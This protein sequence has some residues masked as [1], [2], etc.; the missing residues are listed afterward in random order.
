MKKEVNCV[1]SGTG[2]FTPAESLSNDELV[3]SFNHSV[4]LN[5]KDEPKEK[6]YSNV[7]FIEKASGIKNRF[8]I[9]KSGILDPKVMHPVLPRREDHELSLQAEISLVAAQEALEQSQRKGSEIDCVIV[10]C[11]NM[12]RPYPSISIEIQKALGAQGFAY[13][14]TVACSSAT[15]AIANAS[16]M[17]ETGQAERVLVLSPEIC[18]AQLNYTDRDSHFIF[19]DACTAVVLENKSSVKAKEYFEVMDSYLKTDFSNNIRSNFGFLNRLELD[20]SGLEEKLFV[21]KGRKVFKEVCSM[22][23][24]HVKKQLG[25]FD[26]PAA[27]VKKLWLH[28]ANLSM[29]EFIAK[30]ILEEDITKERVPTVLDRYGNTSS[31]GS[32]IAFH[33]HRDDFC[34]NELGVICSFGAGY[35]MGS[36]LI[37]KVTL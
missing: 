19:G 27:Q 21:Q 9:N 5:V 26:I 28:Q 11:S 24:V 10:S 36:I 6:L 22:V 30:K 7:E 37:K 8:V 20:D 23:P 31:A 17:I 33:L 2:V 16:F 32:I 25:K 34:E 14:M 18:S 15:F 13:D 3:E 12:Q 35:S 1:I 4:D 29:N